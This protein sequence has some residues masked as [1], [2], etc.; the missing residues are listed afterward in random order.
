[1]GPITEEGAMSFMKRTIDLDAET[2]S[3]PSGAPALINRKTEPRGRG[4]L[5]PRV[6]STVPTEIAALIDAIESASEEGSCFDLLD[7]ER[8]ELFWQQ[9]ESH[10]TAHG[11]V[12]LLRDDSRV[13]LQY[14]T[15]TDDER[16]VEDV[17]VLPMGRE[18]RPELGGGSGI[19]WID[20]VE[21]INR[22]LRP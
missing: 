11:F 2:T 19:T 10:S 8:V 6:W 20:D 22:F 18:R 13:Y 7:V 16:P 3:A 15:A 17:V 9:I 1:M 4:H 5:P 21:E 14:I 12:L